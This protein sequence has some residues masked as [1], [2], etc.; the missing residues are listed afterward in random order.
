[1]TE[2]IYL[3]E[4]TVYDPALP[5]EKVLR[6]CTGAGYVYA[7]NYYEPRIKHPG[8]LKRMLFSE[9]ATQS[10]TTRGPSS[11]GFGEVILTNPD[12]ALD[13]LLTYG[14]DGRTLMIKKALALGAA[15]SGVV[16]LAACSMEQPTTTWDEVAIR[17]KDRQQELNVPLQPLKYGGSNA[18]PAGIDGTADIAGK[19][20]PLAF[21]VVKNVT[22]VCVNTSRLIYQ[23]HAGGLS[24]IAAVYDKGITLKAG[25]VYADQA[26]LEANAPAAGEYRVWLAGG[27]FRL[28]SAPS[29]LVTA[30]AVEGAT[31]ADRS[32]AKVIER[33]AQQA[34]AIDVADITAADI[35]ALH[36]A[37]PAEVGYYASAETTVAAAL[38]AVA[39]S[40]GAWYGFDAAGLLRCGRLEAPT[41]EPVAVI[42]D[43]LSIERIPTGDEGRGLPAWK[44][45]LGYDRNWTVQDAG[46]LAGRISS[47]KTWRNIDTGADST[48]GKICYGNGRFVAF[49]NE[50]INAK[51]AATVVSADDGYTWA[52]GTLPSNQYWSGL[53][54]GN[55][56]FVALARDTAIAATSP[57]GV[58]W[59]ARTLPATSNWAAVTYGNGVFVAVGSGTNAAT[60]PDGITWTSRTMPS[61]ADWESIAFGNSIFVAV[62]R[63]AGHIATSPDGITWTAQ[64]SVGGVANL[65]Q[66]SFGNGL[67]FH[68]FTWTGNLGTEVGVSSDGIVWAEVNTSVQASR[69]QEITYGD[70][71]FMAIT[72]GSNPGY[73]SSL[74]GY[75]WNYS[76]TADLVNCSNIAYGNGSFVTMNLS[77]DSFSFQVTASPLRALYLS[78]Q[79]RTV[80]APDSTIQTVHLLA[81]ELNVDTL[82]V[83]AADAQDEADRLLALYSVDR[84]PLRV[85]VP[86]DQVPADV[87]GQILQLQVPRYGY[88]AGKLFVV[89]GLEEDHETG[90]LILV[91]W[92]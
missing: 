35:A 36:I 20:K 17:V 69:I 82:L 8:R 70:G 59:T 89:I 44:V 52:A 10:P 45:N 79:Y 43:P 38:D 29:G 31:A 53:A 83:D 71:L 1:M 14:F 42:T 86:R 11:V 76:Q 47:N 30:D 73:I 54:F 60:S 16:L 37:N 24:A 56:L 50:D 32:A 77:G 75:T 51:Q 7:G 85:K 49:S 64:S 26:D 58:N 62:S 15:L 18:L 9:D 74:D 81:R 57:D 33:I 68:R 22:P 91:I 46:S 13:A 28:G 6:Y 88:N 80:T 34:P 25:A 39:G 92:G 3:L 67:F 4:V 5:G 78:N 90:N 40:I 12:G 21:G 41:G 23:V 66:V 48:R 65:S 84:D 72:S 61:S 19:P 55:G 63:D 87:L 2:I 27:C